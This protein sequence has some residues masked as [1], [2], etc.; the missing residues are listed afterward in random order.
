MKEMN[1]PKVSVIIPTYNR[2][3]F[4][5]E[6]VHSV[7]DQTFTD[8]E[9][10][11][12]DDGSIDN[13]KEVINNYQDSRITYIYQ[14]NQGVAVALNTGV[15]RA[16][17]EYVIFLGS[18]DALVEK[19]LEKHVS[20]LDRY[21]Q[22]AL[23]YGQAYKMDENGRVIGLTK[24]LYKHS[25]VRD[26]KEEIRDLIF[27]NHINAAAV[28]RQ[29]VEK[30]GGFNTILTIAEDYELWVRL[31][32]KWP[33]AYIAEPL[34]KRRRHKHQIMKT[35]AVDIVDKNHKLIL[36]EIFNDNVTGPLYFHLRSSAYY[37]LY[38]TLAGFSYIRRDMKQARKYLLK[39][40]ETYPASFKNTIKVFHWLKRFIT[41]LF[42]VTIINFI[43]HR[44]GHL[45]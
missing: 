33:V 29:C 42:P 24:P 39:A 26:G 16:I 35:I 17:G 41:T 21:T 5:P 19:A 20:I 11:V 18:D 3:Q 23:S 8:F 25:Y 43:R 22:V 30:A 4:L 34:L 6:A 1:I 7:L 12:V 38:Y 27:G 14:E 37:H 13:T 9:I 40:M 36:E 10:I 2:S 31:A 32:K 45:A 15:K 28:R 44:K